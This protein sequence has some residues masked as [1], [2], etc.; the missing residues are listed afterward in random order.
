M[1]NNEI[2]TIICKVEIFYIYMCKRIR[3]AK[4]NSMEIRFGTVKSFS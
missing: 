4:L 3:F 1:N 2:K